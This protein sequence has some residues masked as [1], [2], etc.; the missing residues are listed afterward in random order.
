MNTTFTSEQQ[1]DDFKQHVRLMKQALR[2][3]IGDV[4]G[5]FERR[6]RRSASRIWPLVA[7]A[8]RPKITSAAVAAWW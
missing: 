7:S 3:Q 1:P 2:A 5:L 4:E 8:N 6:G